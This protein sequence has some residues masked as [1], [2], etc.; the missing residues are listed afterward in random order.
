MSDETEINDARAKAD[1]A[2]ADMFAVLG[3]LQRR[4]AP[5]TLVRDGVEAVKEKAGD[6]ATEARRFARR[7]PL[8]AAGAVA[9]ATA[10]VAWFP[11]RRLF[12]GKGNPDAD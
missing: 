7:R 2:R 6:A 4:A 10:A 12:V 11:L 1:A 8:I 9:A 3:E 5:A